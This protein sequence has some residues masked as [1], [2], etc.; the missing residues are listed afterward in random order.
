MARGDLSWI[1]D[2]D[3]LEDY[4][5]LMSTPD[6]YFMGRKHKEIAQNVAKEIEARGLKKGE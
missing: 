5:Y 1:K 3:L 4:E 6:E 2:E